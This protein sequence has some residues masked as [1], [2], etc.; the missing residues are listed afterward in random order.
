MLSP[1]ASV[2]E[3][4]AV[5]FW[6]VPFNVKSVVFNKTDEMIGFL[7]ATSNFFIHQS[8]PLVSVTISFA[9][10]AAVK[11]RLLSIAAA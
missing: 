10:P 7:L 5:I 9:N 1:S 8:L 3:T 11:L 4:L 6:L 2:V